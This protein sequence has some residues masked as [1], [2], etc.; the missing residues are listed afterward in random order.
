MSG[1]TLVELLVVILIIGI[2]AAIALPLFLGQEGKARDAEAKSNAR[3]LVSQ[4]ESCFAREEDYRNCQ[5]LAALGTTGLSLGA[6]TGEVT[7]SAPS[8]HVYTI[9]AL[10]T[11]GTTY[12]IRKDLGTGAVQTCSPGGSGGCASNGSW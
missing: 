8:A 3:N 11:S 2:L 5:T 6:S 12:V 10:S 1:F 9:T 4:V 7:V